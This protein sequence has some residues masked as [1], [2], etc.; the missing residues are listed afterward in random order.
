[1]AGGGDA[2]EFKRALSCTGTGA[3]R[4]R[5]FHAKLNEGAL[6]YLEEQINDWTD[7]ND[8]IEIKQMATQVGVFEGKHPEPHLF[9][10]LFY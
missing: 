6:H 7:N 9:V 4:C 1:M 3:L 5:I 8:N 2:K 10:V